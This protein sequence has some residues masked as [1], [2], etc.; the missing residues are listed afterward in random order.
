[1]AEEQR[2]EDPGLIIIYSS[3][4]IIHQVLGHAGAPVAQQA[5]AA[6]SAEASFVYQ[7]ILMTPVS[8]AANA[9]VRS[10]LASGSIIG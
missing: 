10:R 5:T 1:M 4:E 2:D 7:Q 6:L 9:V 3:D 8:E